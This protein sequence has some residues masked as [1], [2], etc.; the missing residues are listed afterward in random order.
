[1][2]EIVID[3]QSNSLRGT[4]PSELSRF[5]RLHVDI[6]G[7]KIKSIA[8]ELCDKKGWMSGAAGLF[9]CE[10]I[11]YLPGTYNIYGR[12]SNEEKVC[13]KCLTHELLFYGSVVC[14]SLVR[15]KEEILQNIYY[16]CN[17]DN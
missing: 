11:L 15:K 14:G 13:K 10:A 9:G 3:L 2:Q 4:I 8:P 12:M 5:K 16:Q 1:M 7:N 17:G 6:T